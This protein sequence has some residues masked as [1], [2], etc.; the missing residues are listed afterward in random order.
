MQLEVCVHHLGEAFIM[1]SGV[2]AEICVFTSSTSSYFTHT[3]SEGV[4]HRMSLEGSRTGNSSGCFPDLLACLSKCTCECIY[5]D[6]ILSM[7]MFNAHF[8]K[9]IKCISFLSFLNEKTDRVVSPLCGGMTVKKSWGKFSAPESYSWRHFNIL[10]LNDSISFVDLV[11]VRCTAVFIVCV[12][13]LLSAVSVLFNT[14]GKTLW[15]WNKNVK[16]AKTL[17]HKN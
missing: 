13:Q 6:F 12:K 10:W 1:F 8:K 14:V 17:K 5:S 16:H 3:V 9:S 15:V 2:T 11:C 7:L 4:T